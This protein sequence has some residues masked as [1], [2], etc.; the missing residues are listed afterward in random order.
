MEGV[1]PI[2]TKYRPWRDE[3]ITE[4]QY[5]KRAYFNARAENLQVA[6]QAYQEGHWRGSVDE[7]KFD[8]KNELWLNSETRRKLMDCDAS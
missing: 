5:W 4:V 3:G 7:G 1:T 2:K 8:Y 6:E